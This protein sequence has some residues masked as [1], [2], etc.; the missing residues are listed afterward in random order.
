MLNYL[1][2]LFISLNKIKNYSYIFMENIAGHDNRNISIKN[3]INIKN[4]TILFNKKI[5]LR[6]LE[7]SKNSIITKIELLTNANI[8]KTFNSNIAN[9]GLYKNWDF[10]L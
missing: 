7:S 9:G 5:I 6:E 8:L 4:F 2:L 3:E 1:F 10:E